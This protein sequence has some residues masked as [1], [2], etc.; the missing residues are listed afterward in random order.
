MRAGPAATVIAGDGGQP[1][2]QPLWRVNAL[3]QAPRCQQGLLREVLRGGG[4]AG[5]ALA[6]ANQ[7]WALSG[8]DAVEVIVWPVSG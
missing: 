4:V 7:T 6:Q 2:A 3:A 5:E 1:G 8:Q